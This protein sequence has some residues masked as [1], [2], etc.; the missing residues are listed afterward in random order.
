MSRLQEI[1][2]HIFSTPSAVQ[3]AD[4]G[5]LQVWSYTF[6]F[7]TSV[8]V[9]AAGDADLWVQIHLHLDHFAP[10]PL[11]SFRFLQ[12]ICGTDPT[13]PLPGESLKLLNLGRVRM[14]HRV[15]QINV[16]PRAARTHSSPGTSSRRRRG[17]QHSWEHGGPGSC[18]RSTRQNICSLRLAEIAP[19]S[20][21]SLLVIVPIISPAAILHNVFVRLYSACG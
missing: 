9:S 16:P 11:L 8:L 3:L 19:R 20:Q 5:I 21:R 12:K 1:L 18:L 7:W 17:V 2:D 6:A 15:T 13:P 4:N 14:F 10:P